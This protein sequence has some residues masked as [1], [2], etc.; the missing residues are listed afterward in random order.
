MDREK[1]LVK[2]TLILSIGTVIPKLANFLILPILTA[3][4]SKE[5]Y[6][7]YDLISILVSLLIPIVTLQLH[8]AAFRFLIEKRKKK[9]EENKIITNI[10]F[11]TIPTSF[12]SAIILFFILFK[13]SFLTRVLILIYFILEIFFNIFGQISRGLSTNK[14]YAFS[15]AVS[16]ITNLFFT[17]ICIFF[18]KMGLNGVLIAINFSMFLPIVCFII[19]LKILNKIHINLI[20]KK[21]IKEMLQFSL[22][23][24]PTGLSM[25]VMNVSDRVVISL[26]LGIEANAI[27]A[28]A[29][30][31]P[32]IITLAQNTFSLAWQESAS[33]VAD[34]KD[35]DI[36]YSNMYSSVF[37]F[38]SASMIV[39][40]AFMPILFKI[41]IKGDYSDSYNQMPILLL[42]MFFYTISA[43]MGGIY[44]AKKLTKSVGITTII[45]ALVN[46]ITCVGMISFAG[47]YSASI[48]TLIS[49]IVLTVYRMIDIK[50]YVNIKYKYEE[51]IYCML[52][53]ILMTVL[54][55]I[56]NTSIQ[57]IIIIVSIVYGLILFKDFFKKFLSKIKK[58]N[59]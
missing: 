16:S 25:W 20:D 27:Y 4:L 21:T 42:G 23:M 46:L 13:Y 56:K 11:F 5:D 44:T 53:M 22:P 41:L 58:V 26:T 43:Y 54:S 14:L 34:D 51:I 3:Y 17:F 39:I 8:T 35:V 47:I 10:L 33:I 15:S 57:I 50:K 59:K 30:K 49:Y 2:N 32:N 9:E 36:Y 18:L 19:K 28:V 24:I 6:G 29:K 31:I 1:N 7:T 52:F 40:L 48:S 38:M 45:S 37:K 55:Y 12:I